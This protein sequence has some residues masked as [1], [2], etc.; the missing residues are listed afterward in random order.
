[1]NKTITKPLSGEYAPY[2][3]PYVELVGEEEIFSFLDGQ[4]EK[5]TASLKNVP[6][7]M[8]NYRYEKGKWSIKELLSHLN[9]A[10]RVMAYRALAFSRGEQAS[11][12]GFDEDTYVA[13]GKTGQ[14]KLS[15]LLE[16]FVN[17]RKSNVLL[18]KSF[19]KEML[20]ASGVASSCSISVRAQM[21]VIGG[22]TEHHLNVLKKKYLTL[23]GK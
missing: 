7:E 5:L 16:E 4:I 18:F 8:G 3:Q 13:A 17:Q 9:D 14:R 6:E 21:Y 1:M 2:Y 12:P 23:M 19:D 15:D 20:Q 11:L 22:H 10:E